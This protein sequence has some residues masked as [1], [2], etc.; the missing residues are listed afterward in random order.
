MPC[1]SN[2]LRM[3]N[4][5]NAEMFQTDHKHILREIM[6]YTDL[7]DVNANMKEVILTNLNNMGGYLSERV[8]NRENIQD[9]VNISE[10]GV[11]VEL[12]DSEISGD[13]DDGANYTIHQFGRGELCPYCG[14]DTSIY[15]VE[16]EVSML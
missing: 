13:E 4:G 9:V 7:A 6:K 8:E 5:V 3:V 16:C 15:C 11:I 1:H 10:T 12:F 2:T 14:E